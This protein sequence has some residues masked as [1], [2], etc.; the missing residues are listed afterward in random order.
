[1]KKILTLITL[2]FLMTALLSLPIGAVA[3]DAVNAQEATDAAEETVTENTDRATLGFAETLSLFFRENADTLLALLTLIG[4]LLV[5]FLYKTGMLPLLRSGLSAL[6][7]LLGSSRDITERFTKEASKKIS[8]IEE[9]FTP[10]SELLTRGEETLLAFS[11]KLTEIEEKLAKS[12]EVQETTSEVLR[13]ETELFYE[14][15]ASV[16]LPEAQKESMGESYYRLKRSLE[17]RE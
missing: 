11:K 3:T 14:L 5:A 15:L 10:L 8:D 7:D 6:G 12:E 16:N 1:M 9:R 13:T 4:S 17:A 2:L